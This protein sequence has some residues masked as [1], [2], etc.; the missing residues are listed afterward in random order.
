MDIRSRLAAT[1]L[2]VCHSACC[3]YMSAD[4][5]EGHQQ[6]HG[7]QSFSFSVTQ[8]F[9]TTPEDVIEYVE[10]HALEISFL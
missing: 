2:R 3:A 9:V 4:Y 10:T 5:Q 7:E 1:T 8:T 6:I